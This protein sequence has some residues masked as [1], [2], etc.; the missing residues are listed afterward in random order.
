MDVI[1]L[2]IACHLSDP[3]LARRRSELAAGLFARVETTDELADGYAFRF[4][5]TPEV[6]R[7]LLDFVLYER[8]CCAFLTFEVVAERGHGPF[9]LRLRGGEDVKAFVRNLFAVAVSSGSPASG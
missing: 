8:E 7:D 1:D 3:D 5:A 4:P 2:P 9:W 6:A